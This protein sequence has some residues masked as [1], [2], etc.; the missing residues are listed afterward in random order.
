MKGLPPSLSISTPIS[1]FSL[2]SRAFFLHYP[3][4]TC[5]IQCLCTVFTSYDMVDCSLLDF[6]LIWLSGDHILL[7]FLP[8]HWSL[9]CLHVSLPRHYMFK[10]HRA[11]VLAIFFFL[12]ILSPKAF[13]CPMPFHSLSNANHNLSY[14]GDWAVL[15]WPS[16]L[17]PCSATVFLQITVIFFQI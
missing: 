1:S 11:P 12:G 6:F 8:P 15:I 2:L 16:C 13:F 7:Y 5:E 10:Y 9:L 4:V 17:C 14:L 3:H